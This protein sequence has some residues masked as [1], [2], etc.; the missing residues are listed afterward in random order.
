MTVSRLVLWGAAA[1]IF[2]WF[3]SLVYVQNIQWPDRTTLQF[4]AALGSAV[5]GVF[6]HG[7]IWLMGTLF[8]VGFQTFQMGR[9]R[10]VDAHRPYSALRTLR[11]LL[12]VTFAI[13]AIAL[14]PVS[15]IDLAGENHGVP[16]SAP[17]QWAISF[18]V[19][20]I[21][22]PVA[23]VLTAIARRRASTTAEVHS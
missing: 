6:A 7:L 17:A 5:P 9:A 19:G 21:A 11:A 8:V 1:A 13:A 12:W 16:F 2:A 14:L 18:F 20:L 23:L 4:Y 22:G 10:S 15:A 3:A